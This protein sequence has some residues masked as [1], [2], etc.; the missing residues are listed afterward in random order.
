[1]SW[2]VDGRNQPTAQTDMQTLSIPLSSVVSA[3]CPLPGSSG[4]DSLLL[5]IS[6]DLRWH[7]INTPD[8]IDASPL[9]ISSGSLPSL[10]NASGPSAGPM[11]HVPRSL[12]ASRNYGGGRIDVFVMAVLPYVYRISLNTKEPEPPHVSAT[13]HRLPKPQAGFFSEAASLCALAAPDFEGN[14]VI[15]VLNSIQLSPHVPRLQQLNLYSVPESG[16]LMDGPWRVT[17]LHPTARHALVLPAPP[18]LQLASRDRDLVLVLDSECACV[19]SSE[20]L[21]AECT[22]EPC[23]SLCTAWVSVSPPCLAPGHP[24]HPETLTLVSTSLYSQVSIRIQMLLDLAPHIPAPPTNMACAKS[25][26]SPPCT[27]KKPDIPLLPA[28]HLHPLGTTMLCSLASTGVSA[29]CVRLGPSTSS[30]ALAEV[31]SSQRPRFDHGPISYCVPWFPP[32]ASARGP[33]V[34]PALACLHS[35]AHTLTLLQPVLGTQPSSLHLSGPFKT[36]L[37]QTAIFPHFVSSPDAA[38]G[39]DPRKISPLYCCS[40]VFG[41]RPLSSWC[42]SIITDAPT[43]AARVVL[44]NDHNDDQAVVLQVFKHHATTPDRFIDDYILI[45]FFHWLLLLQL[46]H[47]TVSISQPWASPS[48]AGIAAVLEFSAVALIEVSCDQFCSRYTAVIVGICPLPL[49]GPLCTAVTDIREQDSKEPCPLVVVST[50][51]GTLHTILL[52]DVPCGSSSPASEPMLFLPS[53]SLALSPDAVYL[54]S[55]RIAQ[56]TQDVAAIVCITPLGIHDV[57]NKHLKQQ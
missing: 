36:N 48:I 45:V 8:C 2:L 30:G 35:N 17:A 11:S 49:V 13:V 1:M 41:F 38:C 21:V 56:L 47:P 37:Q 55:E 18:G 25:G 9:L 50:Y 22:L 44:S 43:L 14:A 33:A 57:G 31:V 40:C 51:S 39:L 23:L 53:P 5:V 7:L 12:T 46:A 29:L 15:C 28:Q 24:T 20:G 6:V 3:L 26:D 52:S 32:K 19:Y 16:E 4:R 54:Y 42:H 27:F 10:D 34:G